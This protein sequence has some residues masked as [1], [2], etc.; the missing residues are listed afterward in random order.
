MG[1]LLAFAYPACPCPLSVCYWRFFALLEITPSVRVKQAGRF[2]IWLNLE[3]LGLSPGPALCFLT[4]IPW[5]S[6][7]PVLQA[8]NSTCVRTKDWL[9]RGT[10]GARLSMLWKKLLTPVSMS[11]L[12]R[13]TGLREISSSYIGSDR[14][15]WTFFIS[16]KDLP[17]SFLKH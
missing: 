2:W 14:G 15:T 4:C 6:F 17:L 11:C 16:Q 13:I 8:H 9:C 1:S 5:H 10:V 3:G 12:R 7:S